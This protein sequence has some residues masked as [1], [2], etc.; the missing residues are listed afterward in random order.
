MRKQAG[1]GLFGM[2]IVCILIVIVAVAGLKVV[3]AYIEYFNI[4][5]AVTA[6]VRSGEAR[7]ATPPEIRAAFDRR[8]AIDDFSSVTGKD[9]EIT[10]DG[11]DV[12]ISVSYPR[13]IPLVANVS[14]LIDFSASSQ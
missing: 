8:A 4:K 6:I 13:R 5:K 11:N 1:L 9:L 3:P 12:V 2:L 10:K 7:K 14:L